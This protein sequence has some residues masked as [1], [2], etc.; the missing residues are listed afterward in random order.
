M[1]I[2]MSALDVG[3]GI[4]CV[5]LLPGLIKLGVRRRVHGIRA[6]QISPQR[7]IKIG[8]TFAVLRRQRYRLAKTQLIGIQKSGIAGAPFRLIG[9]Q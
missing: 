2:R 6:G 9:H 1:A 3:L 5:G 7:V 8:E 4:E